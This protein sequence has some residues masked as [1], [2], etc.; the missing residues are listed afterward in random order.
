[1]SVTYEC[2]KNRKINEKQSTGHFERNEFGIGRYI[3]WLIIILVTGPRPTRG[4]QASFSKSA[5]LLACRKLSIVREYY[6]CLLVGLF[7]NQLRP[8]DRSNS[9]RWWK[10]RFCYKGPNALLKAINALPVPV[11]THLWCDGSPAKRMAF[12]SQPGTFTGFSS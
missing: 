6:Q 7:L 9:W 8:K 11:F 3:N 4:S 12:F 5:K 1:M 2:T 10:G